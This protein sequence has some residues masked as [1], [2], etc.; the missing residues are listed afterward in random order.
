[1]RQRRRCNIGTTSR[2]VWLIA[3]L[4]LQ[5]HSSLQ[6]QTAEPL[7]GVALVIGQSKYEKLPSLPNTSRDAKAI[8]ELLEKL[9]FK[10]DIAPDKTAR[11]LSRWFDGFI[12]DAESADVALVYYAGHAIE[13]GGM[14]YL[15]P[16]DADVTSL[17]S[18]GENFI[19]LQDMLDRLRMTTR[20]TI[21]LLDACR[22]NPFPEGAFLKY[23]ADA[24]GIP[25]RPTGLGPPRG[26]NV[27]ESSPATS[28]EN[29]GEVIS[30]AAGPGQA[31][32][33]GPA[34]SHSPY[35]AALLKHLNAN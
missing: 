7:K 24:T 30:F 27:I 18:A 28:V 25:I 17:D 29:L 3:V 35:A 10:V 9:G 16:V 22:S 20:I 19:S 5:P 11:Q 8:K 33:D 34:G 15:I 2:L 12:E 23:K 21:I 6:A 14:N 4:L 31:A 1:M 26:M 32:L 13:A